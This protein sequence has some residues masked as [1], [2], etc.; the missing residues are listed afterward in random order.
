MPSFVKGQI[1]YYYPRS[2]GGSARKGALAVFNSETGRYIQ[3]SWLRNHLSGIQSDG[4]YYAEDFR[5]ATQ[6]EIQQHELALTQAVE[7]FVAAKAAV[8]RFTVGDYVYVVRNQCH[9]LQPYKV[10]EIYNGVAFCYR[11][12]QTG[13]EEHTTHKVEELELRPQFLTIN[14]PRY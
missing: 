10:L 1:L 3:I 14:P 9:D 8:P 6:D 12:T 13:E 11:I 7:A 2:S 4:G 5:L